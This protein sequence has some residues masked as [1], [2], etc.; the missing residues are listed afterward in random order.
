MEGVYRGESSIE[1][2]EAMS[3]SN[4][5]EPGLEVHE[6]GPGVLGL[7]GRV[8]AFSMGISCGSEAER[9]LPI[10]TPIVGGAWAVMSSA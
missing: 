9:R 6:I 2:L 7:A 5:V 8:T 10:T 1:L 3:K 4:A